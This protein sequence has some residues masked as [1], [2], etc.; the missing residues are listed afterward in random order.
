MT[1]GS[2]KSRKQIEEALLARAESNESFRRDLLADPRGVLAK[3]FGISISP[4]VKLNVVEET[5]SN[6]YLV[7]P[8]RAASAAG[9]LTDIELELVAG[10]KKAERLANEANDAGKFSK[11]TGGAATAAES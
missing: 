2:F 10:G 7:L 8:A 11:V 9:Q 1:A 6:L 3:D 5:T 4:E